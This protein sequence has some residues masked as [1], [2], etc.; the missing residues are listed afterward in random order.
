MIISQPLRINVF[1]GKGR[2]GG[3]LHTTEVKAAMDWQG[4]KMEG[5]GDVL[6]EGMQSLKKFRGVKVGAGDNDGAALMNRHLIQTKQHSLDKHNRDFISGIHWD[7]TDSL[8]G[9]TNTTGISSAGLRQT[10]QG[11]HQQDSLGFN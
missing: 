5:H 2:R 3:D 6:L 11:F 10:Q 1:L 4:H 7:S 8:E 9:E